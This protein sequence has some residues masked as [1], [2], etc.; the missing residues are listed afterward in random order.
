MRLPPHW[1]TTLPVLAFLIGWAAILFGVG[2]PVFV[3]GTSMY[4]TLKDGDCVLQINYL[5]WS[6]LARGDVVVLKDGQGEAV[7]RIIGLPGESIRLSRGGVIV[8][9]FV[10]YEPYL[11]R[12][13]RTDASSKGTDFT[14]AEGQFFVMGDNRENS[15]DSRDY[16]PVSA[17]KIIGAVDV[18]HHQ[19]IRYLF[20]PSSSVHARGRNGIPQ[21]N[22]A[23]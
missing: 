23:K 3:A 6:A 22:D 17:S 13:T 21:T 19:P 9:H 8:E 20:K 4:P 12:T 1:K 7:K 2:K 18:D 10:L 16:G 15:F 14:L 11:P 5:P